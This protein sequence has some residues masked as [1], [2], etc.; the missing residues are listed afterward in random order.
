M[1]LKVLK[2]MVWIALFCSILLNGWF[3]YRLNQVAR[4]SINLRHTI[5][6]IH[7]GEA[8]AFE[9]E[10]EDM[11]DGRC[12]SIR[13]EGS[14]N[15]ITISWRRDTIQLRAIAEDGRWIMDRSFGEGSS[16]CPPRKK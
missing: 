13:D 10:F 14:Q 6:A 15:I 8:S 16:V 9:T 11:Q 12:L 3:K 1:R 4:E 5:I 2:L 7:D